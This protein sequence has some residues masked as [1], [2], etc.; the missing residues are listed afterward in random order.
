MQVL[1]IKATFPN[2]CISLQKSHRQKHRKIII[3][4]LV[5]AAT[6]KYVDLWRNNTSIGIHIHTEQNKSKL[7]DKIYLIMQQQASKNIKYHIKP[8]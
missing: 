5:R 8:Y 1:N 6:A 3:E 7:M 4:Y 2:N